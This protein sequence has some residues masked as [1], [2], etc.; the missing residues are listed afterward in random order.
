MDIK[1]IIDEWTKEFTIYL[2]YIREMKVNEYNVGYADGIESAI[3]ML[4]ELLDKVAGE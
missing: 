4:H 3:N 1:A 2:H